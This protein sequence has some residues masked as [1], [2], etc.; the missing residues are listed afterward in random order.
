MPETIKLEMTPIETT[1]YRVQIVHY[2]TQAGEQWRAVALSLP[3]VVAEGTSREDVL[4]EIKS[5]LADIDSMSEIVTIPVASL[6]GAAN[7][8]GDYSEQ[9]GNRVEMSLLE[10]ARANGWADYGL[11]ADDPGALEL[12]DEIERERDKHLVGG[13]EIPA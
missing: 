11:F 1:D 4:A 2:P 8:N 7:R 10:R 5:Q 12:F 13:D 3:A 9:N 6:S